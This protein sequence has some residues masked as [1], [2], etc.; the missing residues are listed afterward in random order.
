MS[1]LPEL[2]K[3][4]ETFEEHLRDLLAKGEDDS[5]SIEVQEL[6]ETISEIEE[7]IKKLK[8]QP[9]KSGRRKTRKVKKKH[10]RRRK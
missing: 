5:T 9:K 1:S 10:S 7:Q 2:I 3:E 4:K 8:A 6:K